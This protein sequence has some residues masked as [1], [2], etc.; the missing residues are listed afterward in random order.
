MA[1]TCIGKA[2]N[3]QVCY[4]LSVSHPYFVAFLKCMQS[5]IMLEEVHALLGYP[6]LYLSLTIYGKVFPSTGT[7]TL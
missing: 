4:K 2:N 3:W 7:P 1:I 6:P 5:F